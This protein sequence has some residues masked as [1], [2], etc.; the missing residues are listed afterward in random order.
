MP[1][2]LRVAWAV[3]PLAMGPTLSDR[4]HEWDS[5]TRL[6]AS[7]MLWVGWALV[8]IATCVA[9]PACLAVVAVGVIAAVVIGA[10]GLAPGALVAVV[11]ASAAANAET[12]EW[13]VNGP[14]YANERR[15]PLRIPGPILV[16]PVWL[17]V[18]ATVVGPAAAVMLVA[19]GDYIPG[20]VA[21]VVGGGAAVAGGRALY[22]LTQRW[23]V[24]VPAGLVLH[25]PM[26]LA[27]PVLFERKL[28][29]SL[30]AAPA[31]TDSLDLTGAALG[32]ALE[33]VLTEKVPMVLA[34]GRRNAESG[35]SARLLFTP[36]RPGRVL[37]EAAARRIPVA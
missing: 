37:H 32:L 10:V 15:Y 3:L 28:I 27:D 1:W 35:A 29:E 20:A 6:A 22:G 16:L 18:A 24:F 17:A 14:A 8:A 19:G 11:A 36:T 4:L 7:A 21:A 25:D 5:S 33:M 34:K 23:V 12:V 13:F 9:L 26:G 30:H 31:D 2:V